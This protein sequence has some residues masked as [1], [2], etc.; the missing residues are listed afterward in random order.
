M[1][2]VLITYKKSL[3]EIDGYITDHRA[4]LDV[5]YKNNYFVVSGPK[6]PRTGGVIVSQL[7]N[8]EQ[9]EKILSKD[10]FKTHDVADYEIIEFMPTK[11]H[12]NFS[13]F[14]KEEK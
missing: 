5:G 3:D 8:R 1:F 11:Y 13:T 2:L 14:I 9:L 12:R 7:S 4:F 10:P 6:N